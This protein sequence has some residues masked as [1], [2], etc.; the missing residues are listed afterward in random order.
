MINLILL[1][2]IILNSKEIIETYYNIRSSS[3]G[4]A[5]LALVSNID[6]LFINPAGLNNTKGITATLL[7]PSISS[8]SAIY[9]TIKDYKQLSGAETLIDYIQPHVGKNYGLGINNTT[10]LS[11]KNFSIAHSF[12]VKAYQVL[13]NLALPELHF[14]ANYTSTLKGGLAYGFLDKE[15]LKLGFA[16]RYSTMRGKDGVLSTEDLLTM[17]AS[18]IKKWVDNRGYA[19][20]LDL[21]LIYDIPLDNK[22]IKTSIGIAWQDVFTTKY[23]SR[24]LLEE[25]PKYDHDNLSAGVG[26]VIDFSLLKLKLA[27]DVK[28]ITDKNIQIPLKIHLGAELD[29]LL[30]NIRAGLNQ[31]YYTLG[32]DFDLFFFNLEMA[33]YGE[34]LGSYPGQKVDRRYALK[35]TTELSLF[36]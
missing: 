23:K 13:H 16:T 3:M 30:L 4:G 28:H 31:G 11:M 15:A 5:G 18:E 9:E 27:F 21:G 29:M 17:S 6:S 25:A 26:S 7:S 32:F 24:T 22:L 19:Y 8:N 33:T 1:L 12:E 20:G 34:E 14:N 35:I 36:N 2:N 10:G